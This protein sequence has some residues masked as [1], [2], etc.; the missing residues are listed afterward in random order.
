MLNPASAIFGG[1]GAAGTLRPG[2]NPGTPDD[3]RHEPKLRQAVSGISGEDAYEQWHARAQFIALQAKEVAQV[4][5]SPVALARYAHAS[6]AAD[7]QELAEIAARQAL[8][9]IAGD[10]NSVAV[11]AEKSVPDLSAAASAAWALI[12]CDQSA[13]AEDYLAKLPQSSAIALM[14]AGLAVDGG[15]FDVALALLVDAESSAA[16]SLRGYAYLK[17]GSPVLAIRSLRSAL[18]A[19]ATNADACITMALAFWQ[20]GAQRKAINFARRASQLA[21]GRKDIGLT[22]IDLL[23]DSHEL[24]QAEAEI[25]HVRD[26][27]VADDPELLIRRARLRSLSGDLTRCAALLRRAEAMAKAANEAATAAN[28]SGQLTLIDFT[29]ANIDRTEAVRRIR[30]LRRDFSHNPPLADMLSTLSTRSS[31]LSEIKR[32]YAD[33]E[34]NASTD[35]RLMLK[36]QIARLECRFEDLAGLVREWAKSEPFNS[37]AA[38]SEMMWSAYV[39]LDWASAAGKGKR[40]LQRFGYDS[41]LANN[42]AYVSVL[43]GRTDLA[44]RA[45]KLIDPEEIAS[46]Y[47]LRATRGLVRVAQGHAQEGLR[48]YRK[49]A[50]LTERIPD[51]PIERARMM[52]SQGLALRVIEALNGADSLQVRASALPAVSLPTDWAQIPELRC[53]QWVCQRLGYEWP[54]FVR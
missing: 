47:V 22:L 52:V 24:S 34:E 27:G 21:P 4:Y 11:S 8:E 49:A 45:L 48:D 7:E 43:A 32:A 15:R 5:K 54:P 39:S 35:E 51:A 12:L 16:R 18:A 2:A 31:M 37:L 53:L 29:S 46:R 28:I 13:I 30:R 40:L 44:E 10:S 25:Q 20:L 9:M 23:T 19:D 17:S 26:T 36:M 38:N 14:R 41:G 42:V 3:F 1:S 50:E 6:L 33:V